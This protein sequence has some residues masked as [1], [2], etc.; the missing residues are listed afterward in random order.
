MNNTFLNTVDDDFIKLLDDMESIF[1]GILNLEGIGEQLDI[2]AFSQEYFKSYTTADVSVDANSNVG[3]TDVISYNKEAV[4]PFHRFNSLFCLWKKVKKLEGK[5]IADTMVTEQL[6]GQIYINDLHGAS[7]LPYCFNYS[8]YDIM[9]QG[10]SPV[11]KIK[12]VP[13]KYLYSFKSQLEQFVIIA[14]NSTLGAT[15]LADLFIV[16]A[17]YV[18]NILDTKSDAGFHFATKEDCWKYVEENLVSFIYTINQPM[19]GEQSAFTNVSVYDKNFLEK[20]VENYPNEEGE[21]PD[22]DIIMQ[23]QELYL[24]VMNKE[25][26]RTPITFPVTTACFSIDENNKILDEDFLKLISEKNQDFGFINIYCGSTATLSSCCRLRSNIE[27]EYFN[28]LGSSASK[29][30][31]LGVVTINLPHLAYICENEDDFIER[32]SSLVDL[33]ATINNARRN[34][35]KD[36][37]EIGAHPLYSLGFIDM[38][39]QYSTTGLVG[40]Y[41]TLEILGYDILTKEGQDFV[42]KIL[43]TVNNRVDI[44]QAKYST[45]HNVEQVPAE[46]MAVKLPKKDT[47]LKINKNNYTLYSNQFIPL[48]V[49]TD[50]INRIKLQGMFDSHFS[51]GAIC[52]LNVENKVSADTQAKLIRT[53]ALLGVVYFA[54]NLNLLECKHHHMTVGHSNKCSICGDEIINSFTRV[55][56]FLTNTKNWNKVRREEDYPNR[57]FY[58]EIEDKDINLNK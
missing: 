45:P 18:K 10:L 1:P 56:G 43:S 58:R 14:S 51:G 9:T 8:T 49:N 44:N 35:I 57:V 52:H 40:I 23:I 42:L 16:I 26:K 2:N 47:F 37:V 53:A 28:S 38:N 36:K 7:S 22:I 54:I 46:N 13:P 4:K 29:I 32:L 21:L 34:I 6:L 5:E 39:K 19:R 12:S 25:L 11:K 30:G 31:S 33:T 24:D 41:E 48:V 55:V 3:D 20:Y 27:N 17:H 15:G 50:L